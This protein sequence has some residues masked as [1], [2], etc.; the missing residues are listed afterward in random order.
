MGDWVLN[1]LA[2]V[3]IVRPERAWVVLVVSIAM[4]MLLA[5]LTVG[6]VLLLRLQN[7]RLAR[8]R[9]YLEK[10]WGGPMLQVISKKRP[11]ESFAY[12]VPRGESI[13]FL[14]YL[15]RFAP[16]IAKH[17]RP[18]L[19]TLARPHLPRIARQLSLR[20]PER[21]ARA[22]RILGAL[23]FDEYVDRLRKCLDDPSPLVAAVAAHA[24]M[25][26]GAGRHAAEVVSRLHRFAA[27]DL[28]YLA[29]MLSD[30]SREAD[31]SLRSVLLDP[32]RP[33][34]ERILATE[35]LR[36][37]KDGQA[38]LEA[39][40]MI[41]AERSQELVVALLKLVG[42][43]GSAD[44]LAVVRERCKDPDDVVRMQAYIAVA[45]L[46]GAGQSELLRAALEDPSPWVA[47]HAARSLRDIQEIETLQGVA[48]SDHPRAE[49]VRHVLQYARRER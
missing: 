18:E 30:S 43:A 44:Q 28:R 42:E 35:I 49:M 39:A 37:H 19:E 10:R 21:R 13:F 32:E 22:A 5:F 48:G 26:R 1:L 29:K 31:P 40:G 27:W 38:A 9:A 3:A 23:G 46:G 6:L 25:K 11:A 47:F 7:T 33:E 17:V 24:L 36:S 34:R 14:E 8:R 20:D 41:S 12:L 45:R 4:L 15:M 2:E 16:D